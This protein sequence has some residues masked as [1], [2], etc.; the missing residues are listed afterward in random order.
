MG[1]Q[2]LAGTGFAVDQHV[3]IGLP[4]IEDILAQTLHRRGGADEFLHHHRAVRQFAPQGAVIKGHTPRIA[5]A[6]DQL[7]HP[8]GVEWLFQKIEGADP[9]RLDGHRHIAVSG[10]HDHR[11]TAIQ[12]H[13]LFQERH[14]V[15]TR[16]LDVRDDD[17][18]VIRAND[19]QR[20][21]GTGKGFR[22][23]PR[24]R[25][26]LADRLPHILFV[27]DNRH[28]HRARHVF[29]SAALVFSFRIGSRTSKTAPPACEPTFCTLRAVSLP[30]RSLTIPDEMARPKPT[31]SPG[32]FVV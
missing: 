18:G 26:P 4:Q 15:H 32:F 17:T 5:G 16:H 3:A 14:A 13:Q 27:I 20:L 22:V 6:F 28:F 31:P 7:G 11:Q 9:H 10:D 8:V 30:P 25:Q 29:Y 21:F 24:Q 2:G 23:E 1:G 12:T 19:L